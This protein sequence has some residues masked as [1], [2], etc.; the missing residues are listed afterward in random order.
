MGDRSSLVRPRKVTGSG[1]GLVSRAG[2]VVLDEMASVTGLIDGF[3]DVFAGWPSRR[4]DPGDGYGQVVIALADGATALSDVTGLGRSGLFTQ[5]GSNTTRWEWFDR[6]AADELAGIR[7]AR[8]AAR[9][10]AWDRGAGPSGSTL[11]VDLDATIITGTDTKEDSAGTW[12][13][14]WGHHP[15]LAIAAESGEILGGLLRPGNA[16]SNTAV[17]HVQLLG[18][19]IDD[20]PEPWQV[21]HRPCDGETPERTI[22]VRADS[23]GFSH[24]LI[25]ACDDRN[26][27]FSIGHPVTQAIRDALLLVQEEHWTPA[28]NTNR[29]RRSGAFVAEL[30]HLVDTPGR[31]RMIV[32]RERPHPGAQLN[33][34]D[35]IN[36]WRHQVFI[37]NSAGKPAGLERR[38]RQRGTAEAVIRDLKATGANNLPFSGVVA[39]QAWLLAAMSALD[40]LAWTRA[41]ALPNSMAR[42]TPKTLRYRILHVAG[43]LTPTGRDL[44]L[45]THWPWTRVTLRALQRIRTAFQ[46]PT[47]T[48]ALTATPT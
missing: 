2:L 6:I 26:L 34:F 30:T 21:G 36:G 10:Q 48:T 1:E 14:T 8:A 17:D 19:V 7:R 35:D 45:D 16:G 9:A 28:R 44:H 32:R 11:I 42:A 24:W 38:H 27:E 3:R 41:I 23:A 18:E 22:V 31:A 13:G 12:K 37:T 47:V 46:P 4:L 39:N 43:R 29:T 15:L 33:L 20:L 40:L 5:T 25:E